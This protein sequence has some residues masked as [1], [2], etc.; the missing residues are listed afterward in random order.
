MANVNTTADV[1]AVRFNISGDVYR[2]FG[3]VSRL[4]DYV[5]LLH[6]PTATIV[7]KLAFI[8]D[9]DQV[10]LTVRHY[11]LPIVKVDA[12]PLC[13]PKIARNGDCDAWLWDWGLDNA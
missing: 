1:R 6:M 12:I 10:Q 13:H 9:T 7:D 5:D 3:S 4:R 8:K 11:Q 2:G